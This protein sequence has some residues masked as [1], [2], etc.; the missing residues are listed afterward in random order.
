MQQQTEEFR[1]VRNDLVEQCQRYV[2]YTVRRMIFMMGLPASQY[3]EM[4]SAGYLGL[5][6]A[7]E[8]FDNRVGLDF[9]VYAGFRIRGAIIDS[10]RQ[11]SDFSG[12]AY[13]VAQALDTFENLREERRHQEDATR[14]K[15]TVERLEAIM[16][17]AAKAGLAHRLSVHDK[18]VV[19]GDELLDEQ[20]AEREMIQNEQQLMLER[21]VQQLPEKERIII[22]EHYFNGLPFTVVLWL[23]YC[24][25]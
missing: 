13:R 2:N 7:A 17:L 18:T 1:A 12:R 9:R 16:T 3:D 15:S 21:C 8:R 20:D 24:D 5:V 4:V 19:E 25:C 10:I 11:S 6:E 22:E 14:K 23:N